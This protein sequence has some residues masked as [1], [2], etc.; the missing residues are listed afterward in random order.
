MR[1]K[2]LKTNTVRFTPTNSL[3]APMAMLYANKLINE[4]RSIRF[5]GMQINYHLKW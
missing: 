3:H 4:K 2:Y 1:F 5:L